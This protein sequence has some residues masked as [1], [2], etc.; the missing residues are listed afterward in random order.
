M[1]YQRWQPRNL[2]LGLQR[3]IHGSL[4]RTV[5][6]DHTR[7]QSCRRRWD[8]TN[9]AINLVRVHDN[10]PG[11][12]VLHVSSHAPPGHSSRV[13]RGWFAAAVCEPHGAESFCQRFPGRGNFGE[14]G[15]QLVMV[16]AHEVV[17]RGPDGA[18]T[19]GQQSI[20]NLLHP[21]VK[22]TDLRPQRS[23]LRRSF[24][25]IAKHLGAT[26]GVTLKPS[27]CYAGCANLATDSLGIRW[28]S[29]TKAL[30]RKSRESITDHCTV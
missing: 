2:E 8:S 11:A 28:R 29:A 1:R 17:E 30:Q 7:R 6:L 20:A 15:R 3:F 26:Q 18:F 14:Q 21:A 13:C 12:G 19:G 16:L 27:S 9:T 23:R 5:V 10:L 4:C 22:F 24:A 25:I